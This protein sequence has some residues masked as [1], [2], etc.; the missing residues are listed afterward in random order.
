VAGDGAT[1]EVD[2]T[3]PTRAAYDATVDVYVER[4]G[5]EI[6]EGV[7]QGPELALLDEFV[8]MVGV[9]A[10]IADLGCGPGR[11]IAHLGRQGLDVIGVDLSRGMLSAARRAHGSVAV[12]Q[13]DLAALPLRSQ[14]FD[15]AV[16]W[17]SIVH[18]P[19]PLL[20]ALF[21]EARRIVVAGAP[22]LLGFQAGDGEVVHRD[23]VG[24]RPVSLT[25]VRH[26]PA[27]V[28]AALEEAGL[29]VESTTVRGPVGELES[30]PQAFLL[31]RAT[32]PSAR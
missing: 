30:T 23:Q 32:V 15:G 7:E 22:V 13:A 10:C 12:A 11:M 9:G 31:A 8:R 18:T 6:V 14:A 2:L 24:G 27:A 19:V 29:S 17:Y 26:S 28:A 1:A 3:G 16:F 5:T 4:I 25:N 21:A 20:A